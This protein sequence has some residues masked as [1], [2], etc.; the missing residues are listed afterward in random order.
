MNITNDKCIFKLSCLT[1]YGIS[2][3]GLDWH[4]FA[5]SSQNKG[6]RKSMN[7][8]NTKGCTAIVFLKSFSVLKNIRLFCD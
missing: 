7:G 2:L 8:F 1:K 5:F 6:M 3:L 4:I